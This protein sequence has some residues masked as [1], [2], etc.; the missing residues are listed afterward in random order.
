MG[1]P[2]FTAPVERPGDSARRANGYNGVSDN[3]GS[4]AP[5]GDAVAV[6][7]SGAGTPAVVTAV[8]VSWRNGNVPADPKAVEIVLESEV[9]GTFAAAGSAPGTE[10]P[11]YP[12]RVIA[13][14]DFR[15]KLF[16][17]DSNAVD[18]RA[19]LKYRVE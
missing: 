3:T 7:V 14:T 2:E 9:A 15:V 1:R 4:I 12:D 10:T 11:W 6:D 13:V 5:G 19:T 17:D 8:E 18:Y 16:N